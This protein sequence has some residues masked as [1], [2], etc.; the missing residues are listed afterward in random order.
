MENSSI[1][2]NIVNSNNLIQN[3][4]NVC[5]V[6]IIINLVIWFI[7]NT[8]NN[9][10]KKD[11]EKKEKQEKER[12]KFGLIEIIGSLFA[13]AILIYVVILICK[14]D[15]FVTFLSIPSLILIVYI[16]YIKPMLKDEKAPFNYDYYSYGAMLTLLLSFVTKIDYE[17]YFSKIQSDGVSQVI[18]IIF[19]LFQIYSSMYCLIMN[20]YFVIK[21]LGKINVN[22]LNDKYDLFLNKMYD[23][24]GFDNLNIYF[25]LT[26]SI[27]KKKSK[28]FISVLIIPYFLID[29]FYCLFLYLLSILFTFVLSPILFFVRYLLKLIIKSTET[30]ENH[31]SYGIAKFIS[32][33]S[34]IIVYILL[35]M[36]SVFQ[37]RIISVYEFFSTAI[38]IP[39]ILDSLINFRKKLNS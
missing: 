35:Q 18:V 14:Y 28:F 8:K 15:Y 25:N 3:T 19:L 39:L 38:L 13:C 37:T 11:E 6:C 26:N 5:Y 32:V 10:F 20:V 27:V 21:S 2:A 7:D 33:F 23:V 36:N 24:L 30:N 31:I 1:Y 4:L 34:I 9:N 22:K 17:E 29:V 16:V 12:P